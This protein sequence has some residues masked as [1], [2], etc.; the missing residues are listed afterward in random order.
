M[1]QQD[2][3]THPREG[4]TGWCCILFSWKGEREN[5][6]PFFGGK[7]CSGNDIDQMGM[8]MKFNGNIVLCDISLKLHL[9]LLEM[10]S[11]F[12]SVL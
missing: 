8:V 7:S 9:L 12:L 5:F 2:C 10:W 1:K 11:Y 6:L 4:Y 3:H